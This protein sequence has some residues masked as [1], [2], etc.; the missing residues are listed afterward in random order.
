MGVILAGDFYTVPNLDK[1]GGSGDVTSVWQAFAR[2]F[3]WVVGVA[4]NHD[5]FGNS[6]APAQRISANSHYLDGQRVM[7]SGLVP[8]LVACWESTKAASQTR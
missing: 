3:K 1:R 2:Q 4:G 7:L 5:I 8:G 6:E